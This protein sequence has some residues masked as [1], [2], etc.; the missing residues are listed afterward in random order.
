MREELIEIQFYKHFSLPFLF[1]S[2]FSSAVF[3]CILSPSFYFPRED[4]KPK[5]S[6]GDFSLTEDPVESVIS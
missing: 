5:P 4:V 1:F 2:F 6:A 3:V